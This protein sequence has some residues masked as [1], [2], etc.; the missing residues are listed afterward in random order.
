[1]GLNPRNDLG[2]RKEDAREAIEAD[3]A[4]AIVGAP[5]Q[6]ERA[7]V[8]GSRSVEVT[9]SI[10]EV[11]EIRPDLDLHLFLPG[12]LDRRERG[13]EVRDSLLVELCFRYSSLGA[14]E[15]V[16]ET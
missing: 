12:A 6:L 11:D 9:S 10:V 1:P 3:E 15:Y 2:G 14:T 16:Q 13:A 8:R 7:I 4:S 5:G